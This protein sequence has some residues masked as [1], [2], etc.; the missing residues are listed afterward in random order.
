MPPR[1]MWG[2]AVRAHE[3]PTCDAGVG[4][5]CTIM[6][7]PRAGRPLGRYHAARMDVAR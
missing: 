7:G 6:D 5:P 4:E 1:S 2:A 3:C